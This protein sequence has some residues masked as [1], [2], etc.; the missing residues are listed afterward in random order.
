MGLFDIKKIHQFDSVLRH[1]PERI[2]SARLQFGEFT[3]RDIGVKTNTVASKSTDA[4]QLWLLLGK[5]HHKRMLV[6]QRELSPYNITTRELRLLSI[7]HELGSQA[8]ISAIAGKVERAVAVICDQTRDMEKYGLIKRVKDNPRSR[9]LR[10]ELT[11]KGLDSIKIN[12]KA[13]AMGEIMSVLNAE[14][15]CQLHSLLEKLLVKLNEYPSG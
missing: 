5:I 14:Q 11:K 1:H 6:R 4:D 9:L 7:I 12:R 13:K 15:R 8:T 3:I 10:L 2:R